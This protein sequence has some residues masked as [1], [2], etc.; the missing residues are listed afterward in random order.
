MYLKVLYNLRYVPYAHS[1]EIFDVHV[2]S[3][4]IAAVSLYLSD[5]CTVLY[6]TLLV[7]I[8]NR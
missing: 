6:N 8:P 2:V 1:R 3:Y 5:G 7:S 4:S